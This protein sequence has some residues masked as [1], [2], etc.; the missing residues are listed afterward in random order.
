MGNRSSFAVSALF[1]GAS[2]PVNSGEIAS[3]VQS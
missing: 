1:A 3:P 2:Y